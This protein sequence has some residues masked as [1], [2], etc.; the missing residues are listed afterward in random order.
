MNLRCK[1]MSTAWCENIEGFYQRF[2][3]HGL[4]MS[5]GCLRPMA[6]VAV[7]EQYMI[8]SVATI[9]AVVIFNP[10]SNHFYFYANFIISLTQGY[11]YLTDYLS[12]IRCPSSV[13]AAFSPQVL[14]I[15]SM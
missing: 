6:F 10:I 13:Q 3:I 15:Y 9:E 14:D 8:S 7:V 1:I 4:S 5:C 12:P 2:P 11:E